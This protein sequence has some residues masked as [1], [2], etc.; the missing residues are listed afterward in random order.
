MTSAV[1]VALPDTL[2]PACCC[3]DQLASIQKA[4]SITSP[5]L[6]MSGKQDQLIPLPH[7]T[8]LVR[9]MLDAGVPAKVLPTHAHPQELSDPLTHA[10]FAVGGGQP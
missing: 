9:T 5:V 3:L 8:E 10:L 7:G 6:V 2:A 4:G 1:R